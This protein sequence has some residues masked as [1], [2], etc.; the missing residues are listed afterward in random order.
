ML[1]L[2]LLCAMNPPSPL[3]GVCGD[4]RSL[5]LPSEK[6]G[7]NVPMAQVAFIIRKQSCIFF[8]KKAR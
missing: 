4:R 8:A 7:K 6:C 5:F 1:I 3:T 2:D